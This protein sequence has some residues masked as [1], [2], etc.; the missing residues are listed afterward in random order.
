[1]TYFSL[2]LLQK[3]IQCTDQILTACRKQGHHTYLYYNSM[4]SEVGKGVY[5]IRSGISLI[6]AIIRTFWDGNLLFD[7]LSHYMQTRI[8]Y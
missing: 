6:G 1:V 3:R 4:N 8:R 5:L 2:V 7:N